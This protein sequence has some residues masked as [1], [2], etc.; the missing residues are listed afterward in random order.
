RNYFDYLRY[1]NEELNVAQLVTYSFAIGASSNLP[2]IIFSIYWKRF[3][4]PGAVAAMLTG[5]IVTVVLI[6]LSPEIMGE[7]ALYPL[8]NPGIVSIPLG[9]LAAVI[10]SLLTKPEDNDKI[11][12]EMSVRSHTGLGAE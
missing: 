2:V 7:A 8:T 11:Y 4:T 12:A 10:V 9:F 1:C 6:I 5:T 3:N